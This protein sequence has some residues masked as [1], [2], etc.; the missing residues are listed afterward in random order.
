MISINVSY[1]INCTF[2]IYK[3]YF[4]YKTLLKGKNH[5]YIFGNYRF[6]PIDDCR[7][8]MKLVYQLDAYYIYQHGI[9]FKYT[10]HNYVLQYHH[11]KCM[12][13]E[14]NN[15]NLNLPGP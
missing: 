4:C 5:N 8:S 13:I 2:Y 3:L 14:M 6:T 11:G 12:A 15:I 7:L 10:K 9:D 1:S